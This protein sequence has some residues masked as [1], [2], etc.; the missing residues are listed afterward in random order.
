ME[1]KGH[2]ENEPGVLVLVFLQNLMVTQWTQE[3]PVNI[4]Q[5]MPEEVPT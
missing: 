1:H 5:L 4:A 2:D 3:G